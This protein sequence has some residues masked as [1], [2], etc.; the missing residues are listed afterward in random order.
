M[1]VYS[2]IFCI[3]L[4]FFII[5]IG[6][7]LY[8]F[9]Q[10]IDAKSKKPFISVNPHDTLTSDDHWYLQNKYVTH[11]TMQKDGLN[12]H[13]SMIKNKGSDWVIIVHGYMG[14]LEDMISQAHQFYERGYHVLLPDLRGHGRSD[15]KVV[16]F[17][18]LDAFDIL[19]WCKELEKQG[20]KNILL[21][22]VSMGAASVMMCADVE[23]YP[24]CG[25]IEDCG[26][27]T[28]KGQLT[29]IVKRMVPKVPSGFLIFC[30]SLV[31]KGKAGYRIS[32]VDCLKHVSHAKVPMLFLHGDHDSFISMHMMEELYDVCPNQKEKMV[33][34]GGRH[35]NNDK[36]RP[37]E[38]WT[39]IDQFLDKYIKR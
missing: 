4:L 21:Y 8:F 18:Y 7:G 11:I 30:L 39:C 35:A 1:N 5:C 24:I 28:L 14:R 20:A 37:Q 32:D 23:G 26:F 16:G 12:L 3:F 15:G 33:I 13:A 38:Y 17:G 27:S 19:D 22:G 29:H 25:I 9:H 36:L 31:I 6:I 10:A 34:K 2:I